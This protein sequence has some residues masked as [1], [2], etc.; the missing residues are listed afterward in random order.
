[1]YLTTLNYDITYHDDLYSNPP[2][3]GEI[4]IS[5]CDMT[6][7]H[8]NRKLQSYL[9]TSFHIFSNNVGIE[10]PK[11]TAFP[12]GID[13]HRQF[14]DHGTDPSDQDSELV[15]MAQNRKPWNQRIPKIY[16]NFNIGNMNAHRREAQRL[17]NQTLIVYENEKVDRLTTWSKQLNYAFVASPF[18]AGFDCY[19]T[20]EALALGAIPIVKSSTIDALYDDLP[21]LIVKEWSDI[22]ENLLN[23]TIKDFETQTYQYEK[24]TLAYWLAQVETQTKAREVENLPRTWK[25]YTRSPMGGYRIKNVNRRG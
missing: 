17:I 11:I 16:T 13:Y 5:G 12:H 15:R 9:S 3:K 24:L 1:M 7:D 8:E 4:L 21:V 23:S 2:Q 20:W 6:I 19:R 22:T 18:G 14:E 25:S 10:H